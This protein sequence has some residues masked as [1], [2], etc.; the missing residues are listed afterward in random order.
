[1][2]YHVIEL[3]QNQHHRRWDNLN[4]KPKSFSYKV[5]CVKTQ[6]YIMRVINLNL[7]QH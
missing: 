4:V 1:M 6:T 2:K 3:K 7:T 5:F